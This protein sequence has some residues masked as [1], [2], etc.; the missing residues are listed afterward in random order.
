M[1]LIF[2]NRQGLGYSVSLVPLLLYAICF[3]ENLT[4]YGLLF[5][6][7][8]SQT[9]FSAGSKL[10]TL[11]LFC[12]LLSLGMLIFSFGCR[13]VSKE[14]IIYLTAVLCL[15]RLFIWI[16]LR[17]QINHLLFINTLLI[18]LYTLDLGFVSAF[19]FYYGLK[20]I[21][22]DRFARFI[23]LSLAFAV[24]LTMLIGKFT[25]DSIASNFYLGIFCQLATGGLFFIRTPEFPPQFIVRKI[26]TSPGMRR[27]LKNSI[28]MVVLMSLLHGM[29][30]GVDYFIFRNIEV[31]VVHEYYR[32]VYVAS[33][34][35]ASLI[36][37]RFRYYQMLLAIIA[38]GLLLLNFQLYL[39]G[40]YT[41]VH[42]L[43]CACSGFMLVFM[44]NIF[45][46]ASVNTDKPWLWCNLGRII[47]F[48]LGSI[49][50]LITVFLLVNE[51]SSVALFFYLVGQSFLIFM[52]YH[53]SMNYQIEKQYRTVS[54]R[55]NNELSRKRRSIGERVIDS[56]EERSANRVNLSDKDRRSNTTAV[57]HQTEPSESA[58]GKRRTER[59]GKNKV[60]D[61][62]AY[63]AEFA[64]TQ[65]EA[66]IL[67]EIVQ[68]KTIK[69]M[70][71]DLKINERTVKYRISRIFMKTGTKNQRELLKKLN[72]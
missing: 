62:N 28:I 53:G 6:T 21:S 23:G 67:R 58:K 34:V 70:S 51:L 16:A 42:Y 25:T 22:K 68:L 44:M 45:A 46:E 47:Q 50:T 31:D 48:S 41:V 36:Y 5:S 4:G 30:D 11:S 38:T 57:Y 39:G 9:F 63:I 19:A 3:T 60:T 37:D 32:L 26:R 49:G 1:G 52:L 55:L 35:L 43:D 40:H 17:Y 27:Y 71:S 54:M 12:T 24:A 2:G 66:E 29:S 33:L 72:Y 61:L 18:V 8:I 69:D 65:K 15:V 14:K 64:L 10:V 59:R 56:P 7:S 13:F 20:L